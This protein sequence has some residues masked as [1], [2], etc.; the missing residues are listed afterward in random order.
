MP[1]GETLKQ[2][3]KRYRVFL[4]PKY[5]V[6][7]ILDTW[8]S[9]LSNLELNDDIPDDHPAVIIL[10][11]DALSAVV[12]ELNRLGIS[13]SPEGKAKEEKPKEFKPR[14]KFKYNPRYSRNNYNNL[15]L[16]ITHPIVLLTN[17]IILGM[18]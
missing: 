5:N 6:W 2:Q 14:K 7:R 15:P 9:E 8:N 18:M 4:D 1:L 13:K 3:S 17:I 16:G 12:E 10:P 11:N